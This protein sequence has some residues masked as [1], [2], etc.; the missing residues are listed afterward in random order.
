[1][2]FNI[3]ANGPWF[4]YKSLSQ[5][6]VMSLQIII[7]IVSVKEQ[8]CLI[9]STNASHPKY[10]ADVFADLFYWLASCLLS[11]CIQ[12]SSFRAVTYKTKVKGPQEG[13]HQHLSLGSESQK[14]EHLFQ[15]SKK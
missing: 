14:T 7:I 2:W 11:L 6:S 8:T 1:M 9:Q 12:K 15:K 5:D 13:H 10:T 4:L 3:K